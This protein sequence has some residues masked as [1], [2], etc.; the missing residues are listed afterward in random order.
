MLRKS[1]LLTDTFK[2][3]YHRVYLP[4]RIAL[5]RYIN[6]EEKKRKKNNVNSNTNLGDVK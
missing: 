5:K 6:N 4:R 2:E 3:H 1:F